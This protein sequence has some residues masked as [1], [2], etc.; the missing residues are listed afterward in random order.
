MPPKGKTQLTDDQVRLLSWWINQGAP[1]DKKVAD[2]AI[3]DDI[4]PTLAALGSG[5]NAK[6]VQSMGTNSN[7]PAAP[8]P[9]LTQKVPIPDAKAVEELKKAGLLVMPLS[10]EQNQLEVSA[11]NARS[12]SDAQ[13]PLL[14]KLAPQIVWL[15]L[16]DTQITDAALVQ[17]AQLKNLQ[18]LHL[19][20]TGITDAGLKFLRNLPY[21]EYLNLYGTAVTD[22]GL[23]ELTGFKALKAVFLWHTKVT[24]A[25]VTALK[26][27]LPNL[28]VNTGLEEGAIAAFSP[29]TTQPLAEKQPK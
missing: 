8:S 21:L 17:V 23:N 9:V 20:Q 5:S 18:K 1:F 27:A 16:S 3:T 14:T 11:V 13:A 19:E 12:F 10:N 15:K 29:A 6:P 24:P 25:G 2:L 26:K 28:E 7:A 22:V 4:R